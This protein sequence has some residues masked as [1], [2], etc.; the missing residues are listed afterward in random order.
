M[1]AFASES[2]ADVWP[3]LTELH[4]RHWL[5]TEAARH[6]QPFAP[7]LDRY[8]EYERIGWYVLFTARDGEKLVGN[9]GVYFAPSMHTQELIATEDTLF[10][11]P[12]YRRGHNAIDFIKFVEVECW[13]RGVVEISITAKNDKVGKLLMHL[14]FQPTSVQYSKQKR[15]ADSAVSLAAVTENVNVLPNASPDDQA[16]RLP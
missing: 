8:H 10:L 15:G 9:L 12:E 6:G 4:Q 7:R 13:K 1:L 11:L 16:G 3:E 14:D 5:E 2:G